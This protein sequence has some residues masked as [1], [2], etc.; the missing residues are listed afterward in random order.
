MP[1]WF[2]SM[3]LRHGFAEKARNTFEVNTAVIETR[4]DREGIWPAS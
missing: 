1:N 2:F 3:D 4:L